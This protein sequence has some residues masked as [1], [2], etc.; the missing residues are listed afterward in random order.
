MT[1]GLSPKEEFTAVR[2]SG[3]RVKSIVFVARRLVLLF[4]S[5]IKKK[6]KNHLYFFLIGMENDSIKNTKQT[7]DLIGHAYL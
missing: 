1:P 5:R 2:S 3:H 6:K 7:V 4:I